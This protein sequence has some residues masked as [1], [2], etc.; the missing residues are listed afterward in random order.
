M[1][2]D[3]LNKNHIDGIFNSQKTLF[4]NP[5]SAHRILELVRKY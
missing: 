5:E 4:Q 2:A 1:Y 3:M